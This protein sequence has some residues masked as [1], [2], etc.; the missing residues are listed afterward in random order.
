MSYTLDTKCPQ[1][2]AKYAV[3]I[4]LHTLYGTETETCEVCKC[5]FDVDWGFDY[6]T[7]IVKAGINTEGQ[8]E[9]A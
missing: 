3:E 8:T 5:V 6:D 4:D 9:A 1:C 2:R 7:T